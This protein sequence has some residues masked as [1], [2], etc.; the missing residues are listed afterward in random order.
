[1]SMFTIY[2]KSLLCWNFGL[3]IKQIN[4]KSSINLTLNMTYNNI[5]WVIRSLSKKDGDEVVI[6]KLLKVMPNS[7]RKEVF[8]MDLIFFYLMFPIY[9]REKNQTCFYLWGLLKFDFVSFS[10]VTRKWEKWEDLNL[11]FISHCVTNLLCFIRAIK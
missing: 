8:F 3:K 9:K 2:A 1:M 7:W 6:I 10:L 11:L 5:N 4:P